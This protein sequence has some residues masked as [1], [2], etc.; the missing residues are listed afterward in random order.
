MEAQAIAAIA[1]A[2]NMSVADAKVWALS[3]CGF[4]PAAFWSVQLQELTGFAFGVAS[5]TSRSW[6]EPYHYRSLLKRYEFLDLSEACSRPYRRRF[7]KSK[8]HF[9]AFL[10]STRLYLHHP[11]F[12]EFSRG[13]TVCCYFCYLKISAQFLQV[14]RR[15]I[16]I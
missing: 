3:S 1:M 2:N 5:R 9:A 10:N 13:C 8:A 4:I 6:M 12:C 14:S 11:R 7:L 15:N 16:D